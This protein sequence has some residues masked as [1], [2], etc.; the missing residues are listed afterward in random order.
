MMFDN[1]YFVFYDSYQV[2]F[3]NVNDALVL[4]RARSLWN[5]LEAFKDPGQAVFAITP[6]FIGVRLEE[7]LRKIGYK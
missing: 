3:A 6:R 4:E 2:V 7:P 5:S 1:L